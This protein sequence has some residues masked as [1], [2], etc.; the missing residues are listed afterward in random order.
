[1][2]TIC[3]LLDHEEN[4]RL[5]ADHFR[6]LTSREPA[7]D[8][9]GTAARD[10]SEFEIAIPEPGE[11]AD[12]RFDLAIVDGPAFVRH[13]EELARKKAAETPVFLP[14]L[15]LSRGEA[16]ELPDWVWEDVD[17]IV[18]TPVDTTT[19][20]HRID[21]LLKRRGLSTQL[22]V[23][24]ERSE[25]RFHALF[26]A[27][28]DPV[29]VVTPDGEI[30]DA[31]QS[32]ANLVECDLDDVLGERI[33]N[34][35]TSAKETVERLLLEVEPPDDDSGTVRWDR[36]DG[37][38]RF[39]E[40][41]AEAIDGLGDSVERIGIL[42]DVTLRRQQKREL[43]EKTE[44]LDAFAGTVAHDLRNPLSVARGNLEL[45]SETGE[46]DRLETVEASLARMSQLIDELLTF[47]RSGDDDVDIE[48]VSL[49]EAAATA[50][51]H[52][53]TERA[54]LDV[55]TDG[56]I[57]TDHSRLVELFEN[58]FRNAVEHG[59]STSKQPDASPDD[60]VRI[61][62]GVLEPD[63]LA[64]ARGGGPTSR[65]VT[66]APSGS[67]SRTTVPAFRTRSARKSSSRASPPPRAGRGS[68]SPS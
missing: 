30:T 54:T 40:L 37:E 18:E 15:L 47:A 64:R 61:R 29:V 43:V 23:E 56:E 20:D 38:P 11:L 13:R 35:A 25:Q 67:S 60:T 65:S 45:A 55:V 34:L 48:P 27:A 39:T 19:L 66:T 4:R 52:V 51:D 44:R 33:T 57:H 63:V 46:Y 21:N 59:A 10:H 26:E 7:T 17:E 14:H 58:L 2:N 42:R 9:S 31:N 12:L 68:D 49:R 6:N 3:L 5:L 24:R 1:M 62:V 22:D 41:R 53:E 16:D 36:S 50:W 28:P 32:F 8:G